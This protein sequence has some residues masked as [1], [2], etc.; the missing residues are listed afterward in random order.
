[1]AKTALEK[2]LETRDASTL[3]RVL[4]KAPSLVTDADLADLVVALRNQRARFIAA[5]AKKQEK[6]EGVDDAGDGDSGLE[7]LAD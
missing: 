3:D 7:G 5:D 6:R 4:S 1:M 2:E